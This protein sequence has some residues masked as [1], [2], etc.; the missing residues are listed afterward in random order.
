VK[1]FKEISL[2]LYEFYHSLLWYHHAIDFDAL[3]EVHQ[4]GTG[5]EANLVASALQYGSQGVAGTALAIGAGYV[6]CQ[7]LGVGVTK[8]LVQCERIAQSFF[9]ST[10]PDILE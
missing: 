5:V 4:M 3:S 2:L 7:V 9:I 1:W 10:S 8:V 6:Y